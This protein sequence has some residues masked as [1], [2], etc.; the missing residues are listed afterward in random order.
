MTEE[1]KLQK[2][3]DRFKELADSAE[4]WYPDNLYPLNGSCTITDNNDGTFQ[5][6]VSDYLGKEIQKTMFGLF[7]QAINEVEEENQRS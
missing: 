2:I 5:I 3:K 1:T 4:T 6:H 7:D